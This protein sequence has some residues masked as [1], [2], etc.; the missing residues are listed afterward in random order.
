[1]GTDD[2]KDKDKNKNNKSG[3][4]ATTRSGVI[5]AFIK[6]GYKDPGSFK[7]YDVSQ[8]KSTILAGYPVIADGSATGITIF[9]ITMATPEEGHYWVI[10]G[11]RRMSANVKY[12][13]SAGPVSEISD[14]I[15]CNMGW[16]GSSNGWYISGVFHTKKIPLTDKDDPYRSTKEEDFFQY[17]LGMLTGIR[18]K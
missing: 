7:S 9:G 11:C 17:G 2:S 5:D 4:T 8:V 1:L 16:K 3:A 18:T 12:E 10:D 6:M 13:K 14:Y 15:H